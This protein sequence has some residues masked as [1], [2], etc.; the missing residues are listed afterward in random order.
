MFRNLYNGMN[1]IIWMFIRWQIEWAYRHIGSRQFFVRNPRIS[2]EGQRRNLFVHLNASENNEG[3]LLK[4]D[5]TSAEK[6][7]NFLVSYLIYFSY[8]IF[9]IITMLTVFLTILFKFS[10]FLNPVTCFASQ[11][12]RSFLSFTPLYLRTQRR[13][14]RP[15]WE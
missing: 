2:Y 12:F 3:V 4:R 9:L 14:R 10:M 15:S 11:T 8:F 6:T 5:Q 13:T 1:D 7:V